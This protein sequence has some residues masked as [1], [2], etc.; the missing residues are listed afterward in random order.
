[1][2]NPTYTIATQG[3]QSQHIA[4]HEQDVYNRM[5]DPLAAVERLGEIIASSGMFGCTKVEQGQVLSLIHI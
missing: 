3:G 4:R 1:M 2:N 5:S